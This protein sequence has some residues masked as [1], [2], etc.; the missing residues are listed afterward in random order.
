MNNMDS[1]VLASLTTLFFKNELLEDLDLDLGSTITSAI[2]EVVADKCKR[3][4][5]YVT[6]NYL[7]WKDYS[8][9][10]FIASIINNCV[11]LCDFKLCGYQYGCDVYYNCKLGLVMGC[12]DEET[13]VRHEHMQEF[14]QQFRSSLYEIKLFGFRCLN[15]TSLLV[16]IG[17]NHRELE[18]FLNVNCGDASFRVS[19]APKSILK[20]YC[21]NILC[22]DTYEEA[23][24]HPNICWSSMCIGHLRYSKEEDN[25]MF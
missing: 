9:L 5:K 22:V 18:Y 21:P 4:L 12:F 13:N 6:L 25:V 16:S 14:F 15:N 10:S 3:R 11:N 24:V 23:P 2:L 20:M 7:E 1:L 17:Q 8:H 19:N